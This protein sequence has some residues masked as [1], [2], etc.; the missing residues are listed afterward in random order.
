M[1][2]VDE[3]K[4]EWS[5]AIWNFLQSL[6]EAYRRY[7]FNFRWR[8]AQEIDISGHPAGDFGNQYHTTKMIVRVREAAWREAD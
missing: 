3:V 5:K 8:Q 6:A 4:V 2:S 7:G 1:V